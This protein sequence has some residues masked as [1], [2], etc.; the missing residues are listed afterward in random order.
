MGWNLFRS[1]G[2]SG[3]LDYWRMSHIKSDQ[4]DHQN[5]QT[6]YSNFA[7]KA[8]ELSEDDSIKLSENIKKLTYPLNFQP[9][10]VVKLPNF[11]SALKNQLI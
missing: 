1:V 11:Q 4:V 7:L 3:L 2:L 6:L 9:K 10:L 8:H 5:W